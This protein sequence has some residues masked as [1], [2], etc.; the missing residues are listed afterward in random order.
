MIGGKRIVVRLPPWL[1]KEINASVQHPT[2]P[3]TSLSDFLEVA[4][5]D[6]LKRL[7]RIT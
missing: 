2:S 4:A 7:G 1:L 5:E 6:Y 3:W